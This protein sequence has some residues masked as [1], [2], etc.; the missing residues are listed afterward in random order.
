MI[1]EADARAIADAHLDAAARTYR[2]SQIRFEAHRAALHDAIRAASAAGMS[3]R[4]IAS[5]VEMS[6]GFVQDA[7]GAKRP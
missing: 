7:L 3:V 5:T 2:R 6:T 1:T 4:A